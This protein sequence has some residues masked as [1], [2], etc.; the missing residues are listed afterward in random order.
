MSYDEDDFDYEP[1]TPTISIDAALVLNTPALDLGATVGGQTL[2]DV[3]VRHALDKLAQ[4]DPWNNLAKRVQDI[5]DEEIRAHVADTIRE[6]LNGD[7]RRTNSYGEP[8]GEPTTL[9]ALIG[10]EAKTTLTRDSG[11]Y[12]RRETVL[13]KLIRE[14][15]GNAFRKE[16]S[17]V[18]AKERE[19]VVAAVREQAGQLIAEAVTKGVG[20]K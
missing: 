19:K 14:E 7:L 18:I 11:E 16:L 20:G 2:A 17:D 15:V 3:I 12:G 6:A 10:Q 1:S 13:Q 5:T 8:Y 9:R 4:G